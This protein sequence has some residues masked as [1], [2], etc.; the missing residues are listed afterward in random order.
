VRVSAAVAELFR[1]TPAGDFVQEITIPA[2]AVAASGGLIALET[3]AWFNPAERGRSTD[4]RRLA[5][6]IYSVEVR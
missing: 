6:R 5:L 2:R 4:P 1:F 3:D